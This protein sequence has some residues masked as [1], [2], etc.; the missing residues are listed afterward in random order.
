MTKVKETA[1]LTTSQIKGLLDGKGKALTGAKRDLK[2]FNIEVSAAKILRKIISD[3]LETLNKQIRDGAKGH[4]QKA[5]VAARSFFVAQYKELLVDKQGY[6]FSRTQIQQF[7]AGETELVLG[8][9]ALW[10]ESKAKDAA[11][12]ESVAPAATEE[13]AA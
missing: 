4:K 8:L 12:A 3:A 13:A 9:D 1:G 11:A 5:L 2:R 10:E 6:K 7:I